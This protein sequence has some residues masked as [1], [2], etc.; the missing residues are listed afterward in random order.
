M[1]VITQGGVHVNNNVLA[2]ARTYSQGHQVY[3][4]EISNTAFGDLRLVALDMFQSVKMCLA[5][6]LWNISLVLMHYMHVMQSKDGM[7]CDISR[8]V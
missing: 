8:I 2:V 4:G 5:I 1:V 6:C 3:L 7:F